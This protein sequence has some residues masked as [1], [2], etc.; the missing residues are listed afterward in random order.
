MLSGLAAV[1]ERHHREMP[2]ENQVPESPKEEWDFEDSVKSKSAIVGFKE[3]SPDNLSPEES[4]DH[5][6]VQ[7]TTAV[8]KSRFV[9]DSATSSASV[10]TTEVSD[11]QARPA[12]PTSTVKSVAADSSEVRKGR[13]QVREAPSNSNPAINSTTSEMYSSPN[14]SQVSLTEDSVSKTGR[15][16]VNRLPS[17]QVTSPVLGASDGPK[18]PRKF[19][20]SLDTDKRAE[21]DMAREQLERQRSHSIDERQ[22]NNSGDKGNLVNAGRIANSV[23]LI[24][25]PL[26]LA[27]IPT[28]GSLQE[29]YDTVCRQVELQRTLIQD[30]LMK[31]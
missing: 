25:N 31:D 23:T 8:K 7:A 19:T 15:F 26:I 18:L 12:S 30:L 5:V 22:R 4:I 2:E 14:A 1:T 28:V 10:L 16:E 27:P 17:S 20:V 29:R 9:V 13:F 6:P 21:L 11:S 24:N 3:P